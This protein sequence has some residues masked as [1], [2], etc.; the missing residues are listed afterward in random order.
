MGLS[1]HYRGE[2]ND[3]AALP[4]L[5]YEVK[6]IAEIYKWNYHIFKD[7]FPGTIFT[8]ASP[9]K[10]PGKAYYDWN[11]YGICFTPP[12]C[13]TVFLTFLSDGKMSS[14]VNLDLFGKTVTG[15]ES[16]YIYMLSVKTQFGGIE[17]HKLIIHLLRYLDKKYFKNFKVTD[18]GKY[19]ETGNEKL[20]EENFKRYNDL[21][22][23]FTSALENNPRKIN[24]TFESYFERIIMMI[25][26]K[27]F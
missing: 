16:D 9:V 4:E 14:P 18:E 11:I 15:S 26:K 24:E 25:K 6:D 1:I 19:W 5:I 23:S 21:M 22:E 8:K 12:E 3:T 7:H 13:E 27:K 2:L 20:L 17:V 10:N